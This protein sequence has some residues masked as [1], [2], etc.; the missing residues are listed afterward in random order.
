MMLIELRFRGF[1]QCLEDVRAWLPG[2]N[3]D[4]CWELGRNCSPGGWIGPTPCGARF[5]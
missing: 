1:C 4:H 2:T 5:R 3:W